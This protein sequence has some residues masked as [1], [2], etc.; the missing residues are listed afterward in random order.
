MIGDSTQRPGVEGRRWRERNRLGGCATEPCGWFGCFLQRLCPLVCPGVPPRNNSPPKMA[1]FQN[2]I[3]WRREGRRI[4]RTLGASRGYHA[5]QKKKK[6]RW[7]KIV[8]SDTITDHLHLPAT[9]SKGRP[10]H[11]LVV[12]RGNYGC[13]PRTGTSPI[14]LLRNYVERLFSSRKA[15]AAPASHARYWY[16]TLYDCLAQK[17]SGWGDGVDLVLI[18]TRVAVRPEPLIARQ[19]ARPSSL[20]NSSRILHLFNKSSQCNGE[21]DMLS[22]LRDGLDAGQGQPP[23]SILILVILDPKGSWRLW[24]I[25]PR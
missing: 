21:T 25:Y 13:D 14:L 4:F 22:R 20:M 7:S 11:V 18:R 5:S 8:P 1:W 2:G 9:A 17:P 10:N 15:D 24:R 3:K 6:K 19:A 23:P 16:F 12:L